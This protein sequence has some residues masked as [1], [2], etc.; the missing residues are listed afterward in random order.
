MTTDNEKLWYALSEMGPHFR[1][2]SRNGRWGTC[3][4]CPRSGPDVY[5]EFC[6]DTKRGDHQLT[7]D[8]L[9]HSWLHRLG[10]REENH[11]K[12]WA[13]VVSVHADCLPPTANLHELLE[14][15]HA[16]HNG[17]GG[18]RNHP[19]E[20]RSAKLSTLLYVL[21]EA[22]E[23]VAAMTES[24]LTIHYK[25]VADVMRSRGLVAEREPSLPHTEL[26][27]NLNVRTVQHADGLA[28]VRVDL[29]SV[30]LGLEYTPDAAD[31]FALALLKESAEAR[32]ATRLH[33]ASEKESA[34]IRR[35][36]VDLRNGHVDDDP[37]EGSFREAADNEGARIAAEDHSSD[38]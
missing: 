14:Y 25:L 23:G 34:T 32:R 20:D 12:L 6:T 37:Y 15:H 38:E 10:M 4:G 3:G 21:A 17:P 7:L 8:G 22:D 29:Q 9:V 26:P 13:H 31:A 28:R 5:P 35:V 19:E 24:E 16:E 2:F 18:I 27:A 1:A 33:T 36:L 11:L 30:G